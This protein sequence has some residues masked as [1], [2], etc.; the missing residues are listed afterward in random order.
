M[1]NSKLLWFFLNSTG[2]V[3]RGGYFTFKTEY[4]KPFPVKRIDFKSKTEKFF[5]DK[6]IENVNS[7]LDFKETGKDTFRIEA[8]IDAIVFILYG[9]TEDEMMTT[10]LQ[11]P[12]VSEAERREIQF[13][14]KEY[15]R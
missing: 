10:L 6:I 7:I 8:E 4:L 15:N 9:F 12:D 13:N 1:L 11:M 5:Y 14:F 3:L 2:Y